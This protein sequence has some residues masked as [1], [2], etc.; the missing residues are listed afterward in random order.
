VGE[1]PRDILNVPDNQQRIFQD[2]RGAFVAAGI[3]GRMSQV[4]RPVV[5]RWDEDAPD[6]DDEEA[7][8]RD[9]AE[10]P[11]DPEEGRGKTF[12]LS[13]AFAPGHALELV[14]ALQP[15]RHASINERLRHAEYKKL[16]LAGHTAHAVQQ[17]KSRGYT[18]QG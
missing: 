4:R 10:L 16:L 11:I 3:H 15:D 13:D 18:V 2:L 8:K 9:A 14:H 17:A 1:L 5:S 12:R 6:E 7:P